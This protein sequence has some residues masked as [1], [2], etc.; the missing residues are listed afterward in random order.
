MK[1]LAL[2]SNGKYW[3]NEE[4]PKVEQILYCLK[5]ANIGK[6]WYKQTA[7]KSGINFTLTFSGKYWHKKFDKTRVR[8]PYGKKWQMQHKQ[9]M[10]MI[11]TSFYNWPKFSETANKVVNVRLFL[12]YGKLS[13]TYIACRRKKTIFPT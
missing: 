12:S 4:Q 3:Q 7:A 1:I 10:A 5:V 2:L 9:I 11:G 6:M 8:K 13:A